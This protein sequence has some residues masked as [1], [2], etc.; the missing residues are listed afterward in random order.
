MGIFASPP[1]RHWAVIAR[2]YRDG[3]SGGLEEV[4]AGH[5]GAKVVLACV[6]RCIHTTAPG[7]ASMHAYGSGPRPASFTTRIDLNG[8]INMS[9]TAPRRMGAKG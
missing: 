1:R 8:L 5:E 6:G 2:L 7:A 9:I 4:S 3:T